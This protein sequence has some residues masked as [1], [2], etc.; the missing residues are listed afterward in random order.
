MA[1]ASCWCIDFTAK[2]IS[3]IDGCLNWDGGA[4][5][6]PLAGDYILATTACRNIVFKLLDTFTCVSGTDRVTDTV[7]LGTAGKLV[8]NDVLLGLDQVDFDGV[9]LAPACCGTRGFQ[10]GDTVTGGT[11]GRTGVIRAIEYNDGVTGGGADGDGTIWGAFGVGTWCNDETLL[12]CCG[13][14]C[15]QKAVVDG[16][17]V[18]DGWTGAVAC[19]LLI[20]PGACNTAEILNIDSPGCPIFIPNEARIA[21]S[22]C[23]CPAE[24]AIVQ[25]HLGS[26]TGAPGSL[27]TRCVNPAWI[28]GDCVFIRHVVFFDTLVAGQVFSVGDVILGATCCATARV[29]RVVCDGDSTGKLITAGINNMCG[30]LTEGAFVACELITVSG[31]TIATVE[32]ETFV[33]DSATDINGAPRLI[34]RSCQ[35]GLY[36]DT[37]G[38]NTLRSVN[39]FYT[40]LQDTF[41]ELTQLDDQV[42]MS[43]QVKD[44]QYTLI[45]CW[46][47]PDLAMRWLESGS[48]QTSDNNCIF[49]NYQTLGTVEDITDKVFFNDACC[50]TPQPNFYFEQNGCVLRQDW[51]EGNV[52]VLVKV[53][54]KLDTR[55]ITPA[56]ASLGQLVNCG[57]ITLY[58]R[59]FL[60]T[61]DFFETT[62]VGGTAPTPLAT[63][64]DS[65]NQTGTDSL[66]WC[67]GGACA[68]TVGESVSGCTS[69]ARAIVTASGCGA[70]GLLTFAYKTTATFA[71]C[72][73]VL[74]AVSA[75]C[76]NVVA[77]M[78]AT[79]VAGYCT[80]NRIVP[81][82]CSFTGGTVGGGK[83][84]TGEAVT[85]AGSAATGR[86]TGQ[87][88]A[89]TV[90]VLEQLTGTFNMCGEI[91]DTV[92]CSAYTPTA[93]A[94]TTTVAIDLR[95]GSGD[96]TYSSALGSNITAA[97]MRP[98]LEMYEWT[99][100][101]TRSESTVNQGDLGTGAGVEGRIYRRQVAGFT[102]VK[103]A[104]FGTFAGGTFFGAQGIYIDK[105]CVCACDLQNMVLI[106]NCGTTVNPPNLQVMSVT[107][108]VAC[109]SVAIYRANMC[110]TSC[111]CCMEWDVGVGACDNQSADTTIVVGSNVRTVPLC[112]DIPCM[113]VIRV[114][115][116]CLPVTTTVFLRYCYSAVCRACN[117]FTLS[118]GTIGT[119]S[120]CMDLRNDDDV[121]V[122][123]IEEDTVGATACNT[124]QFVCTIPLLI[125]VREKGILPFE[126]TG[127]F[128]CSGFSTGAIRTTDTIVDLP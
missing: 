8:N 112:S 3:H 24:E 22:A 46:T 41:D 33:L 65:N 25:K 114:Q 1:I 109:D 127:C 26:A 44:G 2:T 77:C 57:T 9:I 62:T 85:Q 35:G 31:T 79:V 32:A 102:E 125:R 126:T 60:S 81:A 23:A 104:P 19:N 75:K 122:A 98:I 43:A 51:L 29:L 69:G 113:G 115:D 11:S 12:I 47:M 45:N 14:T 10:V 87:N 13:G 5:T 110:C 106:D 63:A 68:Y 50:P 89:G 123:F 90:L 67:T 30:C 17:G 16:V 61:Y 56:V 4:G 53:K 52:N 82:Q 28:D 96:H 88:S 105:C 34:Q 128:T 70:C 78:L 37:T 108:L 120:N 58:N 107:G 21:C 59:E 93:T 72:E 101:Q 27:I 99:K 64:N 91:T 92:G 111:I 38:I 83:F 117:T 94:T 86:V 66:C 124:V 39:A 42:P 97:C 40:F 84:Q 116:P 36:Q 71:N 74:G 100:Y 20:N 119:Q 6:Q 15:I 18:D 48:I 76:A 73:Q 118:A 7:T 49:T 95:D 55:F 121:F 103:S 80:N 54:T